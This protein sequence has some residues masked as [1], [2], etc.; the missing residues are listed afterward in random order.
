MSFSKKII[1]LICKYILTRKTKKFSN[2]NKKSKSKRLKTG[3]RKLKHYVIKGGSIYNNTTIQ[4]IYVKLQI[5]SDDTTEKKLADDLTEDL[6]KLD[7]SENQLK[8]LYS[9]FHA[10]KNIA[11][12]KKG[13]LILYYP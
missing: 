6:R 7:A 13:I 2:L 12:T 8:G 11:N 4:N 3:G 1:N 10:G 5:S 9:A